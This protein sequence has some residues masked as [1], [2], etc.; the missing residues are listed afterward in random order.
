MRETGRQN[1]GHIPDAAPDSKWPHSSLSVG[2]N[3]VVLQGKQ[4][5]P[6]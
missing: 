6:P 5:T 4:T 3:G 1:G 2:L